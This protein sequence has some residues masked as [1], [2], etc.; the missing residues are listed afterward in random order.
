MKPAPSKIALLKLWVTSRTPR[1]ALVEG[2]SSSL[3]GLVGSLPL[4]S[5]SPRAPNFA[6]VLTLCEI[7]TPQSLGLIDRPAMYNF[8]LEMR[9]PGGG[10]TM[11]RSHPLLLLHL[12]GCHS[13][14]RGRDG[15][16]DTRSCYT[17]LV[18]ARLLNMLTPGLLPPSLSRSS[19]AFRAGRD[20]CGVSPSVSNL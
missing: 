4:S 13:P 12:L 1:E 20:H 3:T 10:F 7:G 8:L 15:E 16:V 11:H 18:V 2:L 5:F 19:H 9:A 17:A 6:S 14:T